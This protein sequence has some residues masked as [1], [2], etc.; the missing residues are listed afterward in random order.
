M[1]NSREL[2]ADAE[3]SIQNNDYDEVSEII[4]EALGHLSDF[5]WKTGE[6]WERSTVKECCYD[7]GELI[8]ENSGLSGMQS[9]YRSVYA[10]MRGIAARYLEL[11]WNGCGDGAWLG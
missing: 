8:Y 4:C 7:I 1:R 9:V 6:K 2:V 3:K 10:E 11:F 5:V